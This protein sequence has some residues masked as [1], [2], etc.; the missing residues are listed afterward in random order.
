MEQGNKA[1]NEV[2]ALLGKLDR[3]IDEARSRRLGPPAHSESSPNGLE[4]NTRSTIDLDQE[5]GGA[6]SQAQ[7]ELQK[8]GA[9]FGRAKPLNRAPNSW[10]TPGSDDIQIG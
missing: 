10:K 1:F 5:I 7:T 8:R 9:Q 2:R 4:N 6:S 3:T